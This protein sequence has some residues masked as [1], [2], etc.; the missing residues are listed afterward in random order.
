MTSDN[1]PSTALGEN[2]DALANRKTTPSKAAL[3]RQHLA[4]I[5]AAQT[6]GATNTEIVE[7]FRRSGVEI[8]LS[9]FESTLS[10]C[11]KKRGKSTK[12]D[13]A[14]KQKT[15]TAEGGGKKEDASAPPQTRKRTGLQM[16]DPPPKFHW[17]PLE[18]PNITFI[19]ND[20]EKED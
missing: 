19:D 20:H 12:R 18:E 8:S 5:E 10:R 15:A 11:R 4:Q 1:D 17:D 9:T 2:L 7:A 14:T 16:P 13:N 3:I 6:A